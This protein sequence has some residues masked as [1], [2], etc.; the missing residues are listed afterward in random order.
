MCVCLCVCVCVCVCAQEAACAYVILLMAVF[1]CTEVLPLAVTA[2][3][4]TILFPVL[5]IMESKDVRRTHTHTHTHVFYIFVYE[6]Y[7]ICPKN[8][9]IGDLEYK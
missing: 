6:T 2:L 3:L 1:W 4:P 9:I 5:G 7:N 8:S